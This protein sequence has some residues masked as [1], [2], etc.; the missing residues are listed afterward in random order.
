[1]TD[2][3]PAFA[4]PPEVAPYTTPA[5]AARGRWNVLAIVSFVTALLALGVVAV[6]AGHTALSQIKRTGDSGRGL[7]LA[8]VI[9]GYLGIVGALLVVGLWVFALSNG[10]LVVSPLVPSA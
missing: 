8:G 3:T 9:L 1:V 7:A 2:P 6:I 4:T 10:N 5:V